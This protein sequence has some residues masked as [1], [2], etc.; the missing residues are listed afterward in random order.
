M[1]DNKSFNILQFSKDKNFNNLKNKM[2][3]YETYKCNNMW[4]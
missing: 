2:K 3:Q 4:M 1:V